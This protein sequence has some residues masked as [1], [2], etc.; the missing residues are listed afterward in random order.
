MLPV[1][2]IAGSV[3]FF[4]TYAVVRMEEKKKKKKWKKA[5]A[6]P[7]E[8]EGLT[9]GCF[10]DKME[11]GT[12]WFKEQ[13]P[14]KI[15]LTSY[16]GLKLSAYLLPAERKA[17]TSF[18]SCTATAVT[19]FRIFPACISFIMIRDIICWCP[20]REAMRKA[21]ENISVLV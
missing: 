5:P 16:D 17:G 1:T 6:A 9:F 3:A 19:A 21:M 20:T 7:K 12:R 2:A 18:C 8:G 14:E 4:F 11:E 15:T 10:R 13:D